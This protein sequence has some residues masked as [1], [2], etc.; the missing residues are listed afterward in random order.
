VIRVSLPAK[1]T[2]I[3]MPSEEGS[4]RGLSQLCS[5]TASRA[6]RLDF[7]GWKKRFVG[8]ELHWERSEPSRSRGGIIP[9]L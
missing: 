9:A 3:E 5:A 7:Q 2:A 1:R 4:R 8:D 6:R